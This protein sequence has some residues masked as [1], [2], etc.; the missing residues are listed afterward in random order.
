MIQQQTNLKVIDNSGAKT[1]KCIKV[2][3]GAKKKYATLGDFIVISVQKLRKKSKK[4]KKVKKKKFTMLLLLKQKKKLKLK[5]DMLK[6]FHQ[7]LLF[8]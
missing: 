8:Y 6:I 5:L 7:T 3:G 2:L 1:A 4:V